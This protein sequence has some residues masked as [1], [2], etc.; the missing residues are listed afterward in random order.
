VKGSY[1]PAKA[2]HKAY[3]RR[4]YAKYQGMKIVECPALRQEI[5]ARLYDDQSPEAIA[6]YL[7]RSRRNVP[8]ISKESIYRY[9][10]SVYGRR[11]EAYRYR[12]K[13]RKKRRSATASLPGRIFIE[14]RPKTATMRRRVGDAEG[15]T[16]SYREKQVKGC[17]WWWLTGEHEQPSSSG[18]YE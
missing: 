18:S 7:H 1:D 10:A 8:S 17:C 12:K 13:Q 14:K 6:G 3:V 5:V 15:R 4:K 9:L 16:S 2:H 11:I